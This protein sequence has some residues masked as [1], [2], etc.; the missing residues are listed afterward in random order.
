MLMQD[1]GTWAILGLASVPEVYAQAEEGLHHLL[2]GHVD[3]CLQQRWGQLLE[4]L[5]LQEP[6]WKQAHEL[7]VVVLRQDRRQKGV[8]PSRALWEQPKLS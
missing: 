8:Q 6:L 5:Q 4:C 2:H 1:L 7:S 3:Q